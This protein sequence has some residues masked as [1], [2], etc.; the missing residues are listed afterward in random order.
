MRTVTKAATK[1]KKK[2]Y[3]AKGEIKTH[4]QHS[5]LKRKK[6]QNKIKKEKQ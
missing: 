2:K 6:K 3:V 4:R 5:Q 1:K